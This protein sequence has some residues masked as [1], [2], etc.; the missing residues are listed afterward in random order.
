MTAITEDAQNAPDELL[1][2]N[3][4]YLKNFGNTVIKNAVASIKTQQG[5][6]SK[7]VNELLA[8]IK[9]FVAGM[10]A[11]RLAMKHKHHLSAILNRLFFQIQ[12]M[13]NSMQ[14]TDSFTLLSEFVAQIRSGLEN[15]AQHDT[16]L[17]SIALAEC[18]FTVANQPEKFQKV[19]ESLQLALNDCAQ[20]IFDAFRQAISQ[21]REDPNA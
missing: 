10:L 21:F 13:D 8:I 1:S 6:R 5:D 7:T 9:I 16:L 17:G 20:M 11:P 19:F 14:Q 4:V 18:A 15:A 12:Q 2:S 3:A